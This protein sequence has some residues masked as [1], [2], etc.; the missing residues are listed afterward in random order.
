MIFTADLDRTLI[1]SRRRL[2]GEGAVIPAEHRQG[3]AYGFMTPAALANLRRIQ[4]RAV[5]L[6]NTLRGLE[7]AM[8]VGFV[9]DGS[10]RYLALQNGLYLYRDGV[11]DK[12]WA[13]R[14]SRAVNDLP[15]DL[16]QGVAQVLEHLPGIQCLSRQYQYLAV[17][18]LLEEAFD[19]AACAQLAQALADEGWA[20]HRQRKKL[21]LSPLS[22]DKGQVLAHVR[23]LEGDGYAVGFGDSWFDLP[24]LQACDT[25]WSL[26]NCELDGADWGF[27]LQFSSRPGQAGSEEVLR[28]IL[29]DLGES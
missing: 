1:F 19:D 20:L 27:P 25:A 17:F 18:F 24:M 22:I 6:V 10:C 23:A 11:E 16:S 29:I 3:E 8:R 7:Q 5:C 9:A 2:V 28:Q 15:M 12:D 14:V 26:R 13:N 4:D 21:Y